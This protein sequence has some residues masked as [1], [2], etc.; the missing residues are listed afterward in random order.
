MYF[1]HRT[2]TAATYSTQNQYQVKHTSNK[3][4]C[5]VKGVKDMS[6]SEQLCFVN[7]GTGAVWNDRYVKLLQ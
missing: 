3:S 5:A 2:C 7:I 6:V 4:F 1:Y